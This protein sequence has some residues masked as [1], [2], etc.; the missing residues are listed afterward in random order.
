MCFGHVETKIELL[1]QK[2]SWVC[3]SFPGNVF[4]VAFS[5]TDCYYK[6]FKNFLR[7][8]QYNIVPSSINKSLW[9]VKIMG[10]SYCEMCLCFCALLPTETSCEGRREV[11]WWDSQRAHGVRHRTWSVS[12]KQSL[13][14]SADRA[15]WSLIFIYFYFPKKT[16][17]SLVI[18]F[19]PLQS[20]RVPVLCSVF[21]YH[22]E[23]H[24]C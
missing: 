5:W 7:S 18:I 3:K 11:G 13:S 1:Q 23:Y 15:T 14:Y 6:I 24:F 9:V 16:F 19:V 8:L 2:P 21:P 20:W 12:G 10:F 4:C 22:Q 17:V